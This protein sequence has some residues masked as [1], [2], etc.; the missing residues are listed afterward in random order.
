MRNVNG[1]TLLVLASLAACGNAPLGETA[2]GPSEA[3][4]QVS[5]GLSG[6]VAATLDV[7]LSWHG[8]YCARVNIRNLDPHGTNTWAVAVEMNT[9]KFIAGWN[10]HFVTNEGVLT[11]T[12][13]H[14]N[15]DIATN[16][17]A[18]PAPTFCAL[19][20]KA[21]LPSIASAS[22]SYCGTV[23]L[24]SDGDGFGDPNVSIY[25]CDSPT[26]Y[27]LNGGDCCDRDGLAHPG[28]HEYYGQRNACGSFDYDCDGAETP[29]PY[30]APGYC[31]SFLLG[32]DLCKSIG[33][34][35]PEICEGR[36]AGP[37]DAE[38]TDAALCGD[39]IQWRE[40][41]CYTNN[42]HREPCVCW[43]RDTGYEEH[44]VCH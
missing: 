37:F 16:E 30:P 21:A 11:V 44:K 1:Y 20:R 22:A 4:G 38:A 26:G 43:V 6:S 12:P 42:C 41:F 10:G 35:L 13:T 14:F 19:G 25:T 28:Q 40:S 17:P 33:P 36:Y 32:C 24:D 31:R 7:F 9:T 8:G 34:A 15:G 29:K 2:N 23:Y 39:S 5:S 27:V 18:R 3:V